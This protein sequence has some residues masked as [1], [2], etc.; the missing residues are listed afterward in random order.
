[1]DQFKVFVAILIRKKQE[2]GQTRLEF[3]YIRCAVFWLSL[4]RYSTT[5][6][7]EF[8]RLTFR[9]RNLQFILP[10]KTKTQGFSPPPPPTPCSAAEINK[11]NQICLEID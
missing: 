4:N 8:L 10:K 6:I 5:Q 11:L 2:Q 9:K 7:V 3:L 1:M